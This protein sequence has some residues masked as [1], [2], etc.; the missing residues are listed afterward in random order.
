MHDEEVRRTIERIYED[1]R[2]TDELAD[3]E[4]ELLLK[5][6]EKLATLLPSKGLSGDVLEE[7]GDQLRRLMRIINQFTGQRSNMD[8][9]EQKS[10]LDTIVTTAQGIGLSVDPVKVQE[11]LQ[12][13]ANLDNAEN[14]RKLTHLIAQPDDYAP[15]QDTPV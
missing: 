6:G 12:T 1:E 14:I 5:W 8:E 4:A 11:Y 9:D 2:V 15:N 13:H 7:A 3:A 10:T